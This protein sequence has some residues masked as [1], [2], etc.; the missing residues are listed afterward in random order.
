MSRV[1]RSTAE[2]FLLACTLAEA[3][4]HGLAMEV[5]MDDG[6]GNEVTVPWEPGRRRAAEL[7]ARH[8][9]RA[10]RRALGQRGDGRFHP[11]ACARA[12]PRGR[13]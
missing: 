13:A 1:L 11:L 2:A 8:M 6:H 7:G 10:M 5:V 3:R 4:D 9:N 12:I